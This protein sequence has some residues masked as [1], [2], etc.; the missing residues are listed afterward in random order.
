MVVDFFR[1]LSVCITSE[2]LGLETKSEGI[3]KDYLEVQGLGCRIV[4]LS[5]RG[6]DS[7]D[8]DNNCYQQQ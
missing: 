4:G 5:Q 1:G 3:E 2:V 8:R 6:L 7:P